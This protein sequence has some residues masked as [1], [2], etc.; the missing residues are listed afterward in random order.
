MSN[1][2]GSSNLP[3]PANVTRRGSVLGIDLGS[4]SVGTALVNCE[5]KQIEFMGVRVFPAGVTGNL[6]E[7]KEESNSVNRRKARSARRQTQR[8]QRR[9]YKVFRILQ[10]AG[11][12]P[13]GE[14]VAAL[15]ELQRE[16]ERRY[17][18]TTV[19]PW[20]LRSRALDH[21]LERYELGRAIYH[22]A[23]RRGFQSNRVGGATEEKERSEIKAAIEA[24]QSELEASGKRSLAEYMV[25]L[26]PHEKPLRNKA[27]YFHEHYTDRS[28]Y[29]REF[30]L[31]WESQKQFHAVLLTDDRRD[32]LYRAIFHQRPLKDQSH[33]IGDCELEEGEKRAPLRSLAAQRFRVFGFLNNLRVRLDDGSEQRLTQGRRDIALDLSEKSDKLTLAKLRTKALGL[34]PHL[35]F[36]IEEGGEK[37]FPVNLTASRLRT[38]LGE[39]W[40]RL[41]PAQKDDLVEDVGDGK[42]CPTD[43]DIERCAANKWEW[44]P[45]V[46]AELSRVRLPDGYARYSLRALTEILPAIE[47]GLNTEEAIRQRY[48]PKPHEALR[49]LP[50]VTSEAARRVLGE[51]RNPG[52]LRALTELRKTVNAI[53][54]RFGKPETVHVELARDLKKSRSERQRE[55]KRNRGREALRQKAVEELRKYD[56]VRWTNPRNSD[57][58]KCLLATEA[59]WQ[60]PYTAQQYGFSDVFSDAPRVDIEHIIPRSRSLDNSFPNKS[61]AYRSANIEKGSRT[62]REWLY[63]SDRTRYDRMIAIVKSFDPRFD[64]GPK[65]KRFAM[66]LSE[67]DSLLNEF[68]QRQLQDTRYAS[69]LAAKYIGMLFG[70]VVDS[71]GKRRV[72]ACAGQVTAQL[73]RAWDLDRILS[74][75]PAKSRD[76]HRHHAID[77]L[78]V[79]LSSDR[80]IRALATAA[81]DADHLSRRKVILPVPWPDFAAEARTTVEKI[82]VS[83]RPLRKLSGPLHE[84][85][86]YSAPRKAPGSQQKECV[87]YRVPVTSL[88]T[89]KHF[90]DIVD[91]AVR[92]AVTERASQLGG[93][94]NKFQDN[95]PSLLT[96]DGAQVPIKRVR[97]Q[98]VHSVRKIGEQNKQ[99]FVIPGTN[100]HA[101]ILEH[102]DIKGAVKSYSC[103]ETVTLL[104][105]AERNRQKVPVVK[106]T[107]GPGCGFCCT[108]SEGDLIKATRP[109]DTAPR[110]WKVRS[111]RQ[112][113]QLELTPSLDAREKKHIK[114]AGLIWQPNV[115]PLFRS[116]ARKVLV[117]QL[118]EVIAAND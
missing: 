92:A 111:T 60:C 41:S 19:L 118:G 64:S 81:G 98:K 17:P 23:Q 77:A 74:G 49:F 105:A 107:H 46:A 79:S 35:K 36:T 70:G 18:E 87:H 26:N 97:I 96:R 71:T 29:K 33:L 54:R 48:P 14:R 108:L 55:T 20:F 2:T 34:D 94:G 109:G 90:Q 84:E 91:L 112:S 27:D 10:R 82:Q 85:T 16:L 72:T 22:L 30:A 11:L 7:G 116:G 31:I 6:D 21:P 15:G 106:R 75:V 78:T 28:M 67:P 89:P 42:R 88:S 43:Q 58:E 3:E 104:E 47:N 56:P 113:G 53:I 61:L 95:W 114:T 102:Y 12:L 39:R 38:V 40:D 50:P 100:H 52:V 66:E 44:P 83:H 9:L 1:S 62:P 57:I 117:N 59:R 93:G 63:E 80:L 24:L 51:I 5:S 68:T 45:E 103:G 65:L 25:A 115:N 86:L 101:V 37:N 4:Q 99:R 32:K 69:K 8:R 13:P 110:I 73:R 76:D